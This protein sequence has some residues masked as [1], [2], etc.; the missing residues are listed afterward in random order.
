MGHV[1]KFEADDLPPLLRKALSHLLH[2]RR[3]Y[4]GAGPMGQ[5]H[6]RWTR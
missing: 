4:A 6:G 5:Q 1:G 3:V 2:E